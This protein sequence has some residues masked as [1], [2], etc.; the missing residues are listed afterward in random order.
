M[1]KMA[2]AEKRHQSSKTSKKPVQ[3]IS[4]ATNITKRSADKLRSMAV[5][6]KEAGYDKPKIQ[7]CSTS[8][9][10]C[11]QTLRVRCFKSINY[12]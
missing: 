1:E 11:Y 7:P 4:G 5:E 6:K 10:N 8:S 9:L 2:V 12:T 3:N